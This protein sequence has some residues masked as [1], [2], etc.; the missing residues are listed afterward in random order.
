MKGMLMKNICIVVVLLVLSQPVISQEVEGVNIPDQAVLSNNAK[1]ALNGAGVRTKFFFDIYIGALYTENK[2]SSSQQIF[3]QVGSKRVLM[4]FLYD[5]LAKEKITDA[6]TEG[7]KANNSE[8]EYQ[9]L[10]TRLNYFNEFFSDMKKGE[11]VRMDYIPNNGTEVWVNDKLR[12]TIKGS[13]FNIALL[14]VWLG[15]EPADN[16]LKEAMLGK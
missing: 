5:D 8:A 7:F 4:H 13:D 9:K 15:D 3:S 12:G 1:V 16:S 6:W 11:Q 2:S 14:K 10:Q